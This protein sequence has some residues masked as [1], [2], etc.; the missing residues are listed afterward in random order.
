VTATTAV[1]RAWSSLTVVVAAGAGELLTAA[2]MGRPTTC[3]APATSS[4]ITAAH[5]KGGQSIGVPP[6]CGSVIAMSP[7]SNAAGNLTELGDM[8]RPHD[9]LPP[10][11]RRV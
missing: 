2:A 3:Q 1:V 6:C 4:S 10:G 7:S 5:R 9:P 11:L 8:A